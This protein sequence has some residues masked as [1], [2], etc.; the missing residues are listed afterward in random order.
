MYN[1]VST[2][3]LQFNKDFTFQHAE[4]AIEYLSAL[5]VRT[6]YA[7]PIFAAVPGSAHGYDVVNPFVINPEIGT[8]EQLRELTRKLKARGIGWIQDIV[9]NHMAY[10]PANPWL[11][12]VME[13]GILSSYAQAFDITWSGDF[14]AGRLM[15]PFLDGPLEKVIASGE[16]YVAYHQERLCLHYGELYFPL[17]SRSYGEL[18]NKPGMR[19]SVVDFV[20]QLDA[21]HHVTDSVQYA[22]RW[23]ELLLQFA[24]MMRKPETALPL[25][26]LFT[27]TS[28]DHEAMHDLTA[29]QFYRLCDWRE[30][31]KRINYR[32][33]FLVNGL[34]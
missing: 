14:H 27:E 16:L 34:L 21:L 11:M 12:D 31:D 8:E 7:S 23:H 15:A 6:V 9:P 28:L 1:P 25:Q 29:R 30:T 32:R 33:F 19:D 26:E 20:Q 22:L 2:Y 10:H 4:D 18:L 17:N 3:R 5:G 13:K 24:S